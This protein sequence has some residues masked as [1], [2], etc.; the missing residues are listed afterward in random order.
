V[1]AEL[2]VALVASACTATETRATF[3]R[4]VVAYNAGDS[5]ALDALFA[6]EPAFQWYSSNAP[7]ARIRAAAFRRSTLARY[8]E[9]RH[10]QSDRLRVLSFRFNGA[11]RQLG[12]FSFTL[13]RSARDYQHGRPFRIPG[14]G[15]VTCAVNPP[16]FVV[17]SLGGP[18]RP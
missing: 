5:T 9:R 4:F 17:I 10:A 11:E 2:A 7:G 15:A 6:P 14:K 16:A 18:I 12:H 8:F 1:I 3:N 13:R